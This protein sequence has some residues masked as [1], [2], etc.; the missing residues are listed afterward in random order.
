MRWFRLHSR[1]GAYLALL[2]LALQ[3]AL[4]F[5]HIHLK[6]LLGEEHYST[7]AAV[8]VHRSG[9][10]PPDSE[11]P[12]HEGEYCPVYAIN[13]LIGSA[14]SIEPPALVLPLASTIVRFSAGHELRLAQAR[15]IRPRARAPPAA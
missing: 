8:D 14:G 6:Q 12:D 9:A 3:L 15:H 5:G 4:S 13:S 1:G 2:G 11:A 7:A 10:H